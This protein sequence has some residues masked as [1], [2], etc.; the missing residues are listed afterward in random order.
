M[1]LSTLILASMSGESR[2][3]IDVVELAEMLTTRSPTATNSR[4]CMYAAAA[5]WCSSAQPKLGWSYALQF[6]LGRG[7][8]EQLS[9]ASA[10]WLVR[11]CHIELLWSCS[12]ARCQTQRGASSQ[13]VSCS[14]TTP[15]DAESGR[16]E[17]VS[18]A[19][20]TN[21]GA[22]DCTRWSHRPS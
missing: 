12:K 17:A 1:H 20:A 2:L 6:T 15:P 22:H 21:A 7:L 3:S 11:G 16:M 19:E 18:A 13:E 8:T 5:S 4:M 10:L 9:L 14:T